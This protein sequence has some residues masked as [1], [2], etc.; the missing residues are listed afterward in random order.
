MLTNDKS[1]LNSSSDLVWW[2]FSGQTHTHTH[3]HTRTRNAHAHQAQAQAHAHTDT[4]THTH[5]HKPTHTTRTHTHTDVLISCNFC[6]R[7][8][9]DLH[10]FSEH[11]QRS[12][13][14]F[15]PVLLM[16]ISF[17]L[18]SIWSCLKG[19]RMLSC[20][21]TLTT[22]THTHTHTRSCCLAQ[23]PARAAS[24]PSCGKLLPAHTRRHMP[25]ITLSPSVCL[26]VSHP[27]KTH[28]FIMRIK[29]NNLYTAHF[30]G[31]KI[32]N[33]GMLFKI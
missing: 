27:Q 20:C 8:Q 18:K 3:T 16:Q 11:E 25:R 2:G 1:M 17:A 31:N 10:L 21:L 24:R 15:S 9:R 29:Y 19:S 30:I 7:A 22:L 26:S 13:M 14:A 6:R 12:T 28:M 5:T 33:A 4:R 23:R 32:V